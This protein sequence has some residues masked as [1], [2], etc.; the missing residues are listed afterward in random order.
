M[1]RLL[2]YL[3]GVWIEVAVT[4]VLL[5]AQVM[6]QL[7]I[8]NEMSQVSKYIS[9]MQNPLYKDVALRQIWEM[10]GRMLLL[11]VGNVLVAVL[12]SYSTARLSTLYGRNLRTA[13]FRKVT[14]FSVAEYDQFGI[15][16]LITRTSNDVVQMQQIIMLGLRIGVT[17]PVTIIVAIFYTLGL[18]IKLMVILLFSIPLVLL[19]LGF[20]GIKVMPLMKVWQAKIDRSTLVLRENLTGVRVIRAFAREKEE[21]VRYD[22]A[23]RDLTRV[24]IKANRWMSVMMPG[25]NII[26]NFSYLAIFFT[27]FYQFDGKSAATAFDT[28]SQIMSVAQYSLQI[29]MALLMVAMIF[30]FLSRSKVSAIRINEILDSSPT[31]LDPE[32]PV[33][34]D[35]ASC[36]GQLEFRDVSFSFPGASEPTVSH[37]SFTAKKGQTTAIIGSTGSGKSTIVNLIPRLY[38]ATEGQVL[39]D[40]L[41]VR[42]LRQK[43]LRNLIGFVPQKA[44]LFSG[45]IKDNLLFGNEKATDEEIDKALEVAQA[46]HFITKK[47]KG[48]DSE[49]SQSGKNFSGGQKQRLAI[50][51]AL[52][53]KTEIYVFDDS[54][55]AL[56]FKTDV[57]VRHALKGYTKDATVVIVGQRVSSILDADNIIVLD[58]GKVVGQGKHQD[59]LRSC[60]I[61]QE[62][63]RSQLDPEE[64]EN[65]IRLSQL[66]DQERGE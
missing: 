52:C 42:E 54:F 21:S 30:V 57:K 47:E 13:I 22:E 14:D 46:K 5:I 56:D 10:G 31:V 26:M 61:Y 38:D 29:M 2:K 11:S 27:G 8:P 1:L 63:V 32:K 15:S 66:V 4:I 6:L 64:V 44:L 23:N 12:V 62:I 20:I 28:L 36:R 7:R 53:K 19:L 48:L 9:L 49:V 39:V 41:D 60:E 35:Q 45:T 18:N 51:R 55:S 59:L 3:K 25:L 16:S 65:T 43:D 34:L 24:T 33:E 17:S 50:A 37:V 40:G 58:E